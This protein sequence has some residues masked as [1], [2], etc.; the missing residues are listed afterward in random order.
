MQRRVFLSLFGAAT[1]MTGLVAH[2]ETEHLRAQDIEALLSGNTIVGQWS[3]TAYRQFFGTDGQTIY[4]A[5]DG[6]REVGQWRVNPQTDDYE[7]WWR[8]TGWTPY[9]MV[10]SENAGYAWVNGDRLETFELL[11]GRQIE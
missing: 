2:A 8:S 9:A 1:L 4:V 5:T 6:R 11:D 7:S 10:L 3:G